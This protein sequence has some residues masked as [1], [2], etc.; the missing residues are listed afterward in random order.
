MGANLYWLLEGKEGPVQTW[1]PVKNSAGFPPPQS[2][3]ISPGP[4]GDCWSSRG[5]SS[6]LITSEGMVAAPQI[7][8]T[9]SKCLAFFSAEHLDLWS[10]ETRTAAP[11]NPY[12]HGDW[13]L[14]AN[15]ENGYRGPADFSFSSLNPDF[16]NSRKCVSIWLISFQ[17]SLFGMICCCTFPRRPTIHRRLTRDLW[18]TCRLKCKEIYFCKTFL[19]PSFFHFYWSVIITAASSCVCDCACFRTCVR[20]I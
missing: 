18:L 5:F 6:S 17:L 8:A 16:I 3:G 12:S 9:L 13:C 10:R 15:V 7:H 11:S 14:G 19:I 20:E 2:R 4:G 1:S